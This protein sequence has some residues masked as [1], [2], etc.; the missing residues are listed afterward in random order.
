M[1]KF[2]VEI[3][4]FNDCSF[5]MVKIVWLIFDGEEINFFDGWFV[6]MFY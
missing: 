6:M 5:Y 2:Y 1:Y 4:R 3:G